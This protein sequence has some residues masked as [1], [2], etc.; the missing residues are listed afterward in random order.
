LTIVRKLKRPPTPWG[1][2]GDP[3]VWQNVGKRL[4]ESAEPIW[5]ELSSI[6]AVFDKAGTRPADE[7][8]AV[9]AKADRFGA[10]FTLAGLAVEN[11]LNARIL[12]CARASGNADTVG[13]AVFKKFPNKQHDLSLL[14]QWADIRPNRARAQRIC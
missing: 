4:V 2:A 3:Q 8:R 11:E 12:R 5:P 9:R 7:L 6:D 14:A 1:Q 13:E 10:F